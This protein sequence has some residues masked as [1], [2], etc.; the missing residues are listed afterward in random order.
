MKYCTEELNVKLKYEP[1][2]DPSIASSYELI[3]GLY[4]RKG[5][6]VKAIEMYDKAI[7]IRR[8]IQP[9]SHPDIESIVYT[10]NS[11]Q[12]YTE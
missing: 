12:E 10:R 7:E 6:Y 4:H 2:N 1:Q 11:L 3:A 5:E 8:C 9:E